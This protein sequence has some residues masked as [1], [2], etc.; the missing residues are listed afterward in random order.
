MYDFMLYYYYILYLFT[1]TKS[2]WSIRFSTMKKKCAEIDVEA[3]LFDICEVSL[4]KLLG[5]GT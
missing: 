5:P 1:F 4:S 2:K 3:K